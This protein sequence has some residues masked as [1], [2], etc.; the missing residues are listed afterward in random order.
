[1]LDYL[2][3]IQNEILSNILSI[4][5]AI[6]CVY[7]MYK[8]DKTK[9]NKWFVYSA[10]AFAPYLILDTCFNLYIGFNQTKEYILHHILSIIFICWGIVS[11]FGME[12]VPDMLYSSLQFETSTIFLNTR[13]WIFKYLKFVEANKEKMNSKSTLTS[14]IKCLNP[15]NELLFVSTFIYYR[16]YKF[17]YLVMFN[18]DT[19][20][21]LFDGNRFGYINRFIILLI[22]TLYFLNIYW[23]GLMVKKFTKITC[24]LFKH[25]TDLDPELSLIEKLKTQILSARSDLVN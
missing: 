7:F 9:D 19:Y 5:S 8:Y 14:I 21:K 4:L 1:M 16:I 25:N 15:V 18:S 24:N 12:N 17:G 23:L 3:D 13:K 22:Y 6:F 20:V 2:L 11:K 10:Y